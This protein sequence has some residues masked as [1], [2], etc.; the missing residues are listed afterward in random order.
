MP[1]LQRDANDN[2][3]NAGEGGRR[4]FNS[5]LKLDQS[6]GGGSKPSK[7]FFEPEKLKT[8]M[9]KDYL[10]HLAEKPVMMEL[11]EAAQYDGYGEEFPLD[12]GTNNDLMG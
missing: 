4:D 8:K 6:T 3:R 9:E 11:E 7:S 2:L 12:E 1:R 5:F 10:M